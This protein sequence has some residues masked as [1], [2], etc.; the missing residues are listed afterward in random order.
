M[1]QRMLFFILTTISTGKPAFRKDAQQRPSNTGKK[2]SKIV[3]TW[4]SPF[5]H[6]NYEVL[7]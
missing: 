2:H 1:A 5:C 3:S 6:A 7:L 4:G